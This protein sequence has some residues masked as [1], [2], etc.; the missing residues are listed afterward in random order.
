MNAKIV[1]AL[2]LLCCL[3]GTE[4]IIDTIGKFGVSAL[5]HAVRPYGA[6]DDDI[7]RDMHKA[8]DALTS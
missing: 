8:V 7:E 2:V 1:L 4:A 5:C 6:C 3:P